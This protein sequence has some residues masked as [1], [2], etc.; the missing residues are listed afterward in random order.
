[1]DCSVFLPFVA[2]MK[3]S[4]FADGCPRDSRTSRKQTKGVPPLTRSKRV[5]CEKPFE[6]LLEKLA[7]IDEK[8]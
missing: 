4:H 3:L 1:M 8:P 2:T 7:K 6:N 5:P